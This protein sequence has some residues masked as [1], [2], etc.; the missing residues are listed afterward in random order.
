[1]RNLKE[2]LVTRLE[3]VEELQKL[4]DKILT[5][6]RFGDMQPL[7]LLQAVQYVAYNSPPVN[8]LGLVFL[9]YTHILK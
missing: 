2:F 9:D 6:D 4:S 8:E 3:I 5:E 7:L 1:M